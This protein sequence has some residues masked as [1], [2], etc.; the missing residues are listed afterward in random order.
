MLP[1]VLARLHPEFG[2]F[3]SEIYGWFWDVFAE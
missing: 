1:A 2:G 3:S